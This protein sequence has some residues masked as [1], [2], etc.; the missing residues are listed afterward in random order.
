[1][2]YM[3]NWEMEVWFD[4]FQVLQSLK[5]AMEPTTLLHL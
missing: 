5:S 1:M 2:K 4:D 3:E